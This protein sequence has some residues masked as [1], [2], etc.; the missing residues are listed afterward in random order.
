[1]PACF[2]FDQRNQKIGLSF[3]Q[4]FLSQC[5]C[6]QNDS[7][8]RPNEWAPPQIRIFLLAAISVHS[9]RTA[10]WER[11]PLLPGFQMYSPWWNLVR[12]CGNKHWVYYK[13]VFSGVISL[14]HVL[15]Q[16][17]TSKET[18]KLHSL[19]M[20]IFIYIILCLLDKHKC[21]VS[22][23]A[24]TIKIQYLCVLKVH[25]IKTAKKGEKKTKKKH[26]K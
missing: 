2:I 8:W 10:L 22:K 14:L 19:Y 12:K 21:N 1:M 20:Y 15:L 23:L 4:D 17:N 6:L 11:R 16:I 7:L 5:R 26:P 25:R 3:Y 9:E 24:V 18:D 13:I